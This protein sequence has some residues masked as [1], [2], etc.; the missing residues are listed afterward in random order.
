MIKLSFFENERNP[1]LTIFLYCDIIILLH[2]NF[3]FTIS[4]YG[5]L[6]PFQWT[7]FSRMGKKRQEDLIVAAGSLINLTLL[8]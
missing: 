3:F 8:R 6:E 1:I 7:D 5:N 2:D 4:S